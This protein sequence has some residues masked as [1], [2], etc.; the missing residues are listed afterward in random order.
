MKHLQAMQ[1]SAKHGL[2]SHHGHQPYSSGHHHSQHHHHHQPSLPHHQPASSPFATVVGSSDATGVLHKFQA[3]FSDCTQEVSRFVSQL[4]D[5]DSTVKQRLIGHL[6][7]CVSGLPP[8]QPNAAVNAAASAPTTA[9]A[10]PFSFGAQPIKMGDVQ[11]IPSRLPSGELA[12]VMPNSSNLAYFP[13]TATTAASVASASAALAAGAATTTTASM[14]MSASAA[15]PNG[16]A[17]GQTSVAFPRLNGGAFTSVPQ[18]SHHQ[19]HQN[20]AHHHH[21]HLHHHQSTTSAQS[22][23]ISPSTSIS[24]SGDDSSLLSDFQSTFASTTP[25]LSSMPE[26]GTKSNSSSSSTASSLADDHAARTHELFTPLS[27]GSPEQ[28]PQQSQPAF[29][30][31]VADGLLRPLVIATATTTVQQPQ[32]SSTTT[33]ITAAAANAEPAAK[34]KPLSVITNNNNNH[35][36][37]HNNTSALIGANASAASADVGATKK[38]NYAMMIAS[39]GESPMLVATGGLLQLSTTAVEDEPQLQHGLAKMFKPSADGE[40]N[41]D[42]NGD[43]WRPW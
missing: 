21:H 8:T 16:G 29:Q 30:H 3:G 15:Q 1:R 6:N 33:S 43:M 38:R 32:I 31:H 20:H 14:M 24:T 41:D 2:K 26:V 9:S 42:L 25:P 40:L 37:I 23:P 19:Q 5:I 28:P 7:S 27:V 36:N 10:S 11:L 12:L 17:A 4:E 34:V 39:D 35:R 13:T 18:N 22:P